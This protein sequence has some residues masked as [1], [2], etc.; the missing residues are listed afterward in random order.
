M[1]RFP[2]VRPL[3]WGA[4]QRLNDRWIQPCLRSSLAVRVS[5]AVRS[6]LESRVGSFGA[7][8]WRHKTALLAGGST[9]SLGVVWVL[10]RRAQAKPAPL[11]SHQHI[12]RQRS[13]DMCK[14]VIALHTENLYKH[15]KLLTYWK[16]R[17]TSA[18]DPG[19]EDTTIQIDQWLTFYESLVCELSQKVISSESHSYR[20]DELIDRPGV[21]FETEWNKLY[22]AVIA[23]Q[24]VKDSDITYMSAFLRAAEQL[25]YNEISLQF[26][27]AQATES[28]YRALEEELN[29][30]RRR[31][32]DILKVTDI[33]GN[34]NRMA[35]RS[36]PCSI[37]EISALEDELVPIFD[38]LY[39]QGQLS[40]QRRDSAGPVT[41]QTD[42]ASPSPR[43][44]AVSEEGCSPEP[45]LRSEELA[46]SPKTHERYEHLYEIAMEFLNMFKTKRAAALASS[47]NHSS[48]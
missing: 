37:E 16:D 14:H 5:D 17:L 26:L 36:E 24:F 10:Y 47:Q 2:A 45:L 4:L 11:E 33:L 40:S 7:T 12:L 28:T 30:T 44:S 31:L 21:E 25:R 38:R 8:C 32:D 23:M 15:R 9:L 35:Q 19:S 1:I 46:F 27:R 41:Q 6:V 34:I 48:A 13:L 20:L 39:P 43:P 29:N 22:D 3:I 42:D 18:S